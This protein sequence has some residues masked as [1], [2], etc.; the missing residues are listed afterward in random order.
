M[1]YSWLVQ[2]IIPANKKNV[3][4][5]IGRREQNESDRA[6]CD[7]KSLQIPKG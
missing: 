3:T 4:I 1:Y 5:T 7:E 6:G 2:S